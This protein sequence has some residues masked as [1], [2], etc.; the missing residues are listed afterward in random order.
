MGLVII[1]HMLSKSTFGA[2]KNKY[3]LSIKESNFHNLFLS[4]LKG[5]IDTL[6]VRSR[7]TQGSD[8][9]S[10]YSDYL[11]WASI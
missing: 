10:L 1:G 11:I 2:Y 4:F 6:C 9:K 8:V 7:Q 5:V 3:V